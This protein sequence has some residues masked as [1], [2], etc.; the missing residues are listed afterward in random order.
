MIGDQLEMDILCANISR[1]KSILVE[2]R[3]DSSYDL[4]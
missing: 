3:I 4:A 2:P 1:I